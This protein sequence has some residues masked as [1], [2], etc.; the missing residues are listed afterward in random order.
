MTDFV[1]FFKRDGFV[2]CRDGVFELVASVL[3]KIYANFGPFGRLKDTNTEP[4]S[5]RFR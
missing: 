3:F 4:L 5:S 1:N 2:V